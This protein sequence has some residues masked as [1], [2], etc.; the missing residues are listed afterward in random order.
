MPSAYSDIVQKGN[1]FGSVGQRGVLSHINR[2][3]AVSE[4]K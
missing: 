3:K 1:E 4:G 2:K